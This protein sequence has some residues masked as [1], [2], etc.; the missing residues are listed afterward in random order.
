MS[1][2]KLLNNNKRY[3]AV[4]A[5]IANLELKLKIAKDKNPKKGFKEQEW[6]LAV[7]KD[8]NLFCMETIEENKIMDKKY[9]REANKVDYLQGKMHDLA[10]ENKK[11]QKEND[12]LKNNIT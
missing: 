11:L 12:N 2:F 6:I 3:L 10:Q 1:E 5:V 4:T 8:Y 9:L 7:L